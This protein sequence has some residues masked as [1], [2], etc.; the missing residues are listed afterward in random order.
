[1]LAAKFFPQC[2]EMRK[3]YILYKNKAKFLSKGA[4][5]KQDKVF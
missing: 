3:F 2:I 1:M 5:L 4:S